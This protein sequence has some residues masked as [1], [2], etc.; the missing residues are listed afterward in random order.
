MFAPAWA[1]ATASTAASDNSMVACLIL[2]VFTIL[3]GVHLEATAFE[4]IVVL[5]P[6]SASVAASLGPIIN[7]KEGPILVTTTC[8]L[9]TSTPLE[10]KLNA[11]EGWT[12]KA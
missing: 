8:L 9:K 3:S 5:L 6:C 11:K 2:V 4:T 10:N 7:L 12:V 1:S